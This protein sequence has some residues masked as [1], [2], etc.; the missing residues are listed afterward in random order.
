[1]RRK[2]SGAVLP[3]LIALAAVP[4]PLL[5]AGKAPAVVVDGE[6]LALPVEPALVE[7][8]TF[9]PLRG[10]F[11]KQGAQV[12]WDPASRTVR[13]TNG[14]TRFTYV[15][16][17]TTAERNGERLAVPI[18]GFI[19]NGATMV[20]LRLVSEALGSTVHWDES[21]RLIT[22]TSAALAEAVVEWGVNFRERPGMDAGIYRMLPKGET[23]RVLQE[24][25]DDWLKVRAAD[26]T[27]GYVSAAPKYTDYGYAKGA[28]A[29]VAFGET[30][31]GTP[32]EFGASPNQ[33]GTFD[34]SSFVKH[35][36][37][38]V[39]GVELPR[40]SYDQA[41]VGEKVALENL[42]KGD[43]MFF[44]ARGLPIGHVAVY[45]GDGMMLHTYSKTYG[46][47]LRKFE[48]SWT[49]RF[50]TARRVF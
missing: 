1:M 13:A 28:D 37:D 17:E 14:E 6:R 29:L 16:G 38:E 5:A 18:P 23:V 2:M 20:P 25:G 11:E 19:E 34:C 45:A 48:G 47:E 50:V 24:V 39:L 22:I 7:G 3:L 30:Y 41:E 10:V 40:V 31:L 9:V 26:G 42:R 27:V 36:F 44:S 8:T 33:T 35:I 4:A 12:G 32:Y 46:V 49:E 43:L 15:V 21:T